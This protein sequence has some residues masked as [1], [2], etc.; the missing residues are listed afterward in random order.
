MHTY[1]FHGPDEVTPCEVQVEAIQ[2]LYEEG[3]FKRF[4]FANFTKE[5]VLEYWNIA[6]AK[7]YFLPSVYQG[8]Y[9]PA[10]RRNETLLFPTLRELGFSIQAYSPMAGGFLAKTPEY[11]QQGKGLWD[12]DT[13]FGKM[14]RYMYDKP[15]YLKMLEEFGKLSEDSGVSR[16]GLAYRWVR[17]H[18]I[19]RGDLGDEILISGNTTAQVEEALIELEKGPLEAWVADKIDDLWELVKDDAPVDNL[20]AVRKAFGPPWDLA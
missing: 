12:P 1:I 11:I 2:K 16:M 13:P 3:R 19:L 15:S 10:V 20:Q 17:F 7:G 9:S 4:G 5:Q 14:L 6:K 18:S 8:S